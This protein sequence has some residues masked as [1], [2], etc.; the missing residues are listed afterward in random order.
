MSHQTGIKGNFF[1]QSNCSIIFVFLANEEL[2]KFFAKCK[3]GKIR[4]AKISIKD[5]KVIYIKIKIYKNAFYV[6]QLILD[7]YNEIKHNWEKDFDKYVI[8]LIEENQPCYI[9]YR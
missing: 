2:K 5:G 9:F 8:P 3:E 7:G 1:F 4:V 6:E